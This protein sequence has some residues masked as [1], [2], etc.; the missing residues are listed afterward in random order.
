MSLI[1][2][3]C[4]YSNKCAVSI[5]WYHRFTWEKTKTYTL[6]LIK[7]C[8]HYAKFHGKNNFSNSTHNYLGSLGMTTVN[9]SLPFQ[10]G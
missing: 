1:E 9:I 2:S 7:S 3:K 8:A 10:E 5:V 6:I 4:W